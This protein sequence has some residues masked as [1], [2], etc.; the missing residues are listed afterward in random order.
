VKG[1]KAIMQR[2]KRCEYLDWLIRWKEQQIIKVVSGVR[3][4]GK[5]TLFE[6]FIDWLRES[7]VDSKQII[8][9]NF[10]DVENEEISD[11]RLLYDFVKDRL[12][13]DRMN[14]I[15]LDE[16]QHVARYE[17][18]VDSLFIKENCD[19]YITGSNAYF[20]S[21]ELATLLSGR[22]VELKT[23]PLSFAEFY[24]TLYAK[25][26]SITK[27]GAFNRYITL[28]SFPYTLRYNS[29]EKDAKD[30]LRDLYHT[31]ILKDIVA[32]MNITD[33]NALERVIRFMLHNIG[34][35]VSATKVANTLKSGGQGID[36]KTVQKYIKGLCDSLMLYE[37]SRYNIKGKQFLTTQSKYY[38]ADVAL[39]NVM[40]RGK[41]SDIGHILENVV[42]L[43]LKRRGYDVFVG[44]LESDGEVDFVVT[45]ANSVAYYQVAASTLDEQ[46]L[47]RELRPLRKIHDNYPKYLLTLDEAFASADYDGI[48]KRNALDWLLGSS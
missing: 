47:E 8:S 42:F 39:R 40:V 10:E 7:G 46:T 22:Y 23:L 33:E 5:S 38:V 21:S 14:Y 26:E 18:A 48:Q 24:D 32:R 34:N 6:I 13:P 3:R 4:S 2:I 37:A 19:V 44:E 29:S 15:F 17:K 12:L 27:A 31:I 36:P 30:Y 9:L 20:M 43:E 11:Y 1:E 25:K 45:D 41:D 35:I 28:G 16:I